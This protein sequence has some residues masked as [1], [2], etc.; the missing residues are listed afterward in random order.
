MSLRVL[1]LLGC[2]LACWAKPAAASSDDPRVLVLGRI[3]DDPKS[4]Y[5]QLKPLIATMNDRIG[6]L[7]EKLQVCMSAIAVAVHVIYHT[8]S[9]TGAEFGAR[10]ASRIKS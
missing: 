8:I 6:A 2:L 3:S 1:A 5:E 9:T 10:N 7:E 4:H